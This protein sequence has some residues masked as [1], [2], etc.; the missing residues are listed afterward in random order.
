M[1]LA[2]LDQVDRPREARLVGVRRV[3]ADDEHAPHGIESALD[4]VVHVLAAHV[5]ALPSLVPL[6]YSRQFHAQHAV[7]VREHLG[8]GE[9]PTKVFHLACLTSQMQQT[10]GF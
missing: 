10:T 7:Y 4:V 1:L 5:Y 8:L 6:L 2:D 9:W 3:A